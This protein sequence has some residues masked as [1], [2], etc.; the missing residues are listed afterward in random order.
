VSQ[1]RDKR[2]PEQVRLVLDS[3]YLYEHEKICWPCRAG[4]LAYLDWPD[5]D[6]RVNPDHQNCNCE[7]DWLKSSHQSCLSG[8]LTTF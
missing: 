6:C 2:E 8:E 1:L 7:K 4:D 5:I 3:C